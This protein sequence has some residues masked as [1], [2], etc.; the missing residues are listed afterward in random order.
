MADAESEHRRL[1]A[2]YRVLDEAGDEL[3]LVFCETARAFLFWG[4]CQ[5]GS[6]HEAYRRAYERARRGGS[7]VLVQGLPE[8]VLL[9]AWMT[10]ASMD[11]LEALIGDLERGLVAG[12]RAAARRVLSG[13]AQAGYAAGRDRRADGAAGHRRRSELF[14]QAGMLVQASTARMFVRAAI[15]LAEADAAARGEASATRRGV[16]PPWEHLY[17]A[18]F[19]GDWAISLCEVGDARQARAVFERA[20]ALVMEGDVADEILL[21]SV[22]GVA[23]ALE[24]SARRLESVSSR[25]SRRRSGSICSS[26]RWSSRTSMPSFTGS[27]ATMPAP[28]QLLAGLVALLEERGMHRF[29]DRF[30]RDLAVLGH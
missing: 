10:H 4:A 24:A 5:S 26:A 18:N 16:E 22:G 23:R 6:A 12:C 27:W 15:P 29:A 17:G 19:L 25:P 11:E 3:G 21:L 30:R 7:N 1:D 14:E 2:A 9:T 28:A 13:R 8:F 20:R